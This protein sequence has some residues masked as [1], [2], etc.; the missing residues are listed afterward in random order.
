MDL[1]KFKERYPIF[2]NR[3]KELGYYGG[4]IEKYERMVRLILSEGGDKSIST[5]EQFYHYMVEN[6]KYTEHTCYEYRNHIG[7]LKMFVEDGIFPEDTV[8]WSGFMRYKSYNHLSVDFKSL[9]D[10]YIDIERKRGKRSESSITY[11][12]S[13][14]SSFFCCIQQSG[15]TTLAGIKNAQTVLQAFDEDQKRHGS[16]NVP[17]SISTVLQTCMHLYPNGECCRIWGMLPEFPRRTRLYDHLQAEENEKVAHALNEDGNNLTYRSKAIGKLAYYTGMRRIDIANLRFENINLEKD[18]IRF[19]QQKTGL[20]V[21]IPLRPVVGNAIYDYIVNERPKCDSD[22][23]FIRAY[24][25]FI[26]LSP[27]GVSNDSTSIFKQ[28]GIRQQKTIMS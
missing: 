20:E 27:A 17:R 13:H 25:P 22:Y 10:S 9:I 6:H 2:L 23:I 28:A 16:Y 11:I 26:K 24:S 15:V 3:M 1:V 5:Y 7:R 8:K 14:T 19:I 21:C 18:E 4:Y 12:V